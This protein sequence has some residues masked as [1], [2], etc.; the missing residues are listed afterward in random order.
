MTPKQLAL[1]HTAKRA[2]RLDDDSYRAILHNHGGVESAKQLD[3]AGFDRVVKYFRAQGF[4]PIGKP[5]FGERPG[6]A[7]IGQ[8]DYIRSLVR[9]YSDADD[10]RALDRWLESSFKVTALRF[11]TM[12]Q[13][14]KAITGLKL[15][16][17][18]KRQP[19]A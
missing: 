1:L 4:T 16:A 8:V 18:R 11:L 5:G 12:Q 10:D 14:Q 13:A 15:M 2:L 19:A 6:M 17:A 3:A 9:Q 7:T